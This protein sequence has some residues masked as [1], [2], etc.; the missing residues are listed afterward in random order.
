LVSDE[1][2]GGVLESLPVLRRDRLAHVSG[3]AGMSPGQELVDEL[4]GDGVSLEESG[5]DP[6]AE[7]AHEEGGVPLRQGQEVAVR[8]EAA[9]GGEQV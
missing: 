1:V 4:R 2:S 6:L 8:G 9:V 3:E 7:E 5:E